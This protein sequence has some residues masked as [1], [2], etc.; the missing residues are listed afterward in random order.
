M[1]TNKQLSYRI[2]ELDKYLLE[3]Y[4]KESKKE[5]KKNKIDYAEYERQYMRRI[6][7]VIKI[8]IL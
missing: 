4:R 2:K 8:L 3:K 1:L 5:A 6:K 7:T